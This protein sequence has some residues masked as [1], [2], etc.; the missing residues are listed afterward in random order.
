MNHELRNTIKL[1][2][3]PFSLF[4]MPV[5]LFAL[6]QVTQVNWP[7][8]IISFLVLHLFIYPASNGY[9]SYEDQ[10][11]TSIGGLEHP[12]KPTPLLFY[13]ALLF[14]VLGLGLSLLVNVPFF[15]SVLAYMLASRAYSS[16]R[17]RLKKHPIMGFLTVVI[18]QGGF[19]FWMA[20]QAIE[21]SPLYFTWWPILLGCS[22]L[23]GGVYPLTQVYQHEADQ[24]NNDITISLLLGIRGTF[25]FSILM[26]V[27]ANGLF[28]LHFA[29]IQRQTDFLIFQLCLLPV[30][31]Y[32]GW[33]FWQVWKDRNEANFKNTMRMN[34]IASSC[35]N[36][37]FVLLFV[38]KTV[39]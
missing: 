6:S 33:W 23:I 19:T 4:L 25:L 13:A 9:N 17:I 32:F 37:C 22:F 39:R 30:L 1:L 27:L 2:R 18:F 12:P 14:D 15:F 16:K 21:L 3:I 24:A 20:Y 11:E 10:D 7:H 5:F 34:L 31:A 26:F 38:L 36:L 28:F 29:N 8:A 35:M